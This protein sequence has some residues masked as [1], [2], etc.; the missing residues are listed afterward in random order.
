MSLGL[1]NFLMVGVMSVLFIVFAKIIVTKY[2]IKGITPVIQ[3]V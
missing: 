3:A 1:K 2:P